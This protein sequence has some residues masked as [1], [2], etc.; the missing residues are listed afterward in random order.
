M[1]HHHNCIINDEA[2]GSSH[3]TE[4]HD[5]ETHFQHIKQQDR[6]GE[7]SRHSQNRDQRDFPVAKKNKQNESGQHHADDDCIARAVFRRDN[8]LALIVPVGDLHAFGNLL[9]DFAQFR[10]DAARDFDRVT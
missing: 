1:F 10:L 4:R 9:S 2:N 7:D 5:V 3:T 6:G 8:E